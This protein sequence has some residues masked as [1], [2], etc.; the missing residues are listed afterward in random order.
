MKAWEVKIQPKSGPI[1]LT[2]IKAKSLV[3][4]VRLA[5]IMFDLDDDEGTK[6]IG[7]P[8]EIILP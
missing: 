4:A 1:L 2:E 3:H 7:M 5:K 8:K 6:M